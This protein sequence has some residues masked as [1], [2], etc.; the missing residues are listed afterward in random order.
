MYTLSRGF[1]KYI[2]IK[3]QKSRLFQ[4]GLVFC[5][6]VGLKINPFSILFQAF[7]EG[8]SYLHAV[9]SLLRIKG[10]SARFI[11]LYDILKQCREEA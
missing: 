4:D 2:S 8:F 9:K 5:I 1:G 10:K 7:D 6:M 3:A 11:E